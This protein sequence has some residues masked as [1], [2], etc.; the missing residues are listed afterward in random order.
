M[1][2]SI[3]KNINKRI[4]FSTGKL[5]YFYITFSNI[6]Y[7]SISCIPNGTTLLYDIWESSCWGGVLVSLGTCHNKNTFLFCLLSLLHWSKLRSPLVPSHH[8]LELSAVCR[9]GGLLR[10]LKSVFLSFGS[11]CFER[12]LLNPSITFLRNSRRNNSESTFMLYRFFKL[13]IC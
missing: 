9:S 4:E 5:V 2:V 1:H 7:F 8:V 6:K 12:F 10:L 13:H 11:F 3:H